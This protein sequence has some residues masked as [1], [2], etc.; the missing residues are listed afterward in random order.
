VP[1]LRRDTAHA[2]RAQPPANGL[3]H[4]R[5]EFR[6]KRGRQRYCSQKCWQASP[7]CRE[8]KAK[9]GRRKVARP[10]YEQL[11]ADLRE[12]SRVAVGRKYGVS[13]NAVRKWLRRYEAEQ[14]AA[15]AA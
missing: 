14:G 11:I 15:A 5:R 4:L 3:P 7:E 9:A 13:D 8:A 12:L 1:E 6:K 2:L 10:T